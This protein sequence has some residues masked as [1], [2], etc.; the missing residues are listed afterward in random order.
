MATLQEYYLQKHWNRFNN[1]I[2][3]DIFLLCSVVR[4]KVTEND[5]LCLSLVLKHF[6][7]IRSSKLA[8]TCVC[9][10]FFKCWNNCLVKSN[11]V[12]M[13]SATVCVLV[14]CTLSVIDGCKT[15]LSDEDKMVFFAN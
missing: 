4:R 5:G 8:N 10:K 1:L 13:Y 12:S 9:G 7:K 6:C 3:G 2:T 15:A 14:V 11:S